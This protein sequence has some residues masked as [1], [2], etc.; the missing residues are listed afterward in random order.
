M[1][2]M[3]ITELTSM[4]E[5]LISFQRIYPRFQIHW[6]E[7]LFGDHWLEW[8]KLVNLSSKCCLILSSTI[9]QQKLKVQS[10]NKF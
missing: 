7:D 4:N 2:I 3:V 6:Q 8:L 1:E 10:L 5:H 9:F